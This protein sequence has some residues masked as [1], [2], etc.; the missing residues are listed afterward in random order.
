MKMLSKRPIIFAAG[1]L[2]VV[3]AMAGGVLVGGLPGGKASADTD[4]FSEARLMEDC[5]GTALIPNSDG[6]TSY[7]GYLDGCHYEEASKKDYW[8]WTDMDVDGKLTPINECAQPAGT[9]GDSQTY[10]YSHTTTTT[11]SFG[12][13]GTANV[14]KGDDTLGNLGITASYGQ[15]TANQWGNQEALAVDGQQRGTWALG[16]KM[17]HSEGRIRVNYSTPVGP[18]DDDKHY[19]WYI[20]DVKIDTPYTND[21]IGDLSGGSDT[22][23]NLITQVAPDRVSCDGGTLLSE[24]HPPYEDTDSPT[25]PTDHLGTPIPVTGSKAVAP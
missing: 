24:L 16:Q 18:S 1:T 5:D 15:S 7:A 21:N 25:P 2:A 20:N 3:G 10:S 12:I 19:I 11:W 22:Q 6:G 13:N 4:Y 14:L 23:G 17:H 9:K 8:R